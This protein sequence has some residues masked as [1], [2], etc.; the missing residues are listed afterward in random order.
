MRYCMQHILINWL[1]TAPKQGKA[2]ANRVAPA[3]DFSA[4]TTKTGFRLIV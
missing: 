1:K 4:E 2:V 3:G